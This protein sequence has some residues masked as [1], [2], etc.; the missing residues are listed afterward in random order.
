[1]CIL[2]SLSS[3]FTDPSFYY[4]GKHPELEATAVHSVPGCYSNSEDQV[5]IM[6]ED[7][8]G[9]ILF[10]YEGH[11][12]FTTD[13]LKNRII[14]VGIM[15]K[16]ENNTVWIIQ[17]KN[18]IFQELP[19]VQELNETLIAQYFT[20]ETMSNLKTQNAWNQPM[21]EELLFAIPYQKNFSIKTFTSK[22]REILE[23]QFGSEIRIQPLCE[24]SLGEVICFL[25]TIHRDGDSYVADEAYLLMINREESMD[26]QEF[27]KIK[28]DGIENYQEQAEEFLKNIGW[29]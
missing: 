22:E 6:E 19:A 27:P 12:Y 1:M 14:V 15:Q 24:N 29:V 5:Y 28:L 9:R 8:Y 10:A 11:S 3:C 4:Q 2:F 20:E 25:R 16:Q 26:K 17:N 23:H 13:W 21:D 18:I 7:S